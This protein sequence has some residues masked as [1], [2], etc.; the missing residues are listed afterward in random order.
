MNQ[1]YIILLALI[2]V[3][4][5]SSYTDLRSHRISNSVTFP[6]VI[7]GLLF[8]LI[9]PNGV[10]FQS[11][12]FGFVLGYVCLLPM[13]IAGGMA[14]G[15]VKLMG[16]VGALVGAPIIF[17][18][19]LMTLLCGSVLGMFWILRFNG[20]GD[21]LRRYFLIG[22]M[23][24]MTGAIQYIPPEKDSPA[25]QRFPYAIA[26]AGGTLSTLLFF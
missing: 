19:V 17:K 12:F 3:L 21:F 14:A 5:I 26:I 20:G 2:S 11:A 13:Y 18:V 10:G 15:D 4:G 8:N 22:K 25:L 24:L 23:S 1:P 16:A 9:L 6:A 7:L